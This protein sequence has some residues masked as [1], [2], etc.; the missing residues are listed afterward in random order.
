MPSRRMRRAGPAG[1]ERKEQ[2]KAVDGVQVGRAG[3]G[4]LSCG[5]RGEQRCGRDDG[6]RRRWLEDAVWV[7]NERA[8]RGGES[9]WE[10]G[11]ARILRRQG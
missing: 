5:W 7:G 1:P 3:Q 10:S 6:H 11:D 8:G 2:A 4:A 9:C